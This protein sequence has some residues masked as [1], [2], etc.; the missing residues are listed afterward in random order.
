MTDAVKEQIKLRA[1]YL[2]GLALLF[3]GLGALG[4]AL[5]GYHYFLTN[6]NNTWAEWRAHVMVPLVMIYAGGMASFELHRRAQSVLQ[7]LHQ[8]KQTDYPSGKFQI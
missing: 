7:Q 8:K 3:A 2:N 6:M 4:L 1:N 5:S